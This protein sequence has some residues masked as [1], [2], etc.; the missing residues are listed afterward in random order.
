MPQ[1]PAALAPTGADRF[2]RFLDR[3]AAR[4]EPLALLAERFAERMAWLGLTLDR[5]RAAMRAW[6][7][8]RQLPPAARGQLLPTQL[9]ALA[10]VPSPADRARLALQAVDDGWTAAQTADEVGAYRLRAGPAGG[11]APG[12]AAHQGR[13]R[14]LA[15]PAGVGEA[16]GHAAAWRAPARRPV[17][18]ATKDV[19]LTSKARGMVARKG[20][21]RRPFLP[22]QARPWAPP[23]A[24]KKPQPGRRL[25]DAPNSPPTATCTFAAPTCGPSRAAAVSVPSHPVSPRRPDTAR[26][27]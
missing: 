16:C 24:G 4:D 25:G 3:A 17:A 21:V 13:S 2:Q 10:V 1:D 15:G 23:A 9:R 7:V 18:L 6:E 22:A 5:I 14:A 19:V 11:A 8:D 20:G 26:T 12:T 27:T